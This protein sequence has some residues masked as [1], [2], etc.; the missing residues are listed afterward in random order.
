MS[1]RLRSLLWLGLFALVGLAGLLWL[2]FWQLDR[3]AW[4][5]NLI[6]EVQARVAAPPVEA[7]PEADWAKLAPN[8]YEY[9]HVRLSGVYE[10]GRQVFVFRALDNPHGRFSG[11]G[12]LVLTPLRLAD[13]PVVIVNRGFIPNDQK[14]RFAAQSD[15]AS[16]E[17]VVTGLMRASEPRTWFTPPDDAAH[18]QWFTRDPG[19]IAAALKLERAAPFTIDA[20][21][22]GSPGDL[23]QGGET[24][25]AFPN[26]H[27]GY[28]F[29]WFGMALALA[30]VFCAYAVTRL[31]A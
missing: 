30:G 22:T 23:P 25:L 20:D 13:G 12:Y 5:E 27:L 15:K 19:A 24:I 7:P 10:L 26:N 31:R 16:G 11:P 14:A 28:A 2:G 3:L 18:G 17:T 21:A 4:K 29:T 9:R 8:D 6:A 1:A